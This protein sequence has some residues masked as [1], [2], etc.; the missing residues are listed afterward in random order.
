HTADIETPAIN[1][2]GGLGVRYLES[3]SPPSFNS[4]AASVTSALKAALDNSGLPY[5][6]LGQEP[7]RTLA[8]EAGVTLYTVGAIKTVSTR[9]VPGRRMYVSIDGGL[10]DNPRPQLYEAAYTALLANRAAEPADTLVTI[11]GKHCETDILIWDICLP[12]PSPG[13]LLAVQ[14]TGAYNY[15]MASNYNRFQKP[16]VV[17]VNRGE[18]DLI[19]ERE[20]LD[21]LISKDRIPAR[22][23]AP[24]PAEGVM[25]AGRI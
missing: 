5:P 24:S 10:S 15:S 9:S 13:D 18:A 1:I 7:G 17:L 3:D 11:A 12:M 23:A 19:V 21:D 14:T 20:T 22:L 25:A 2:G 6:T 8:A 16:A 4:F